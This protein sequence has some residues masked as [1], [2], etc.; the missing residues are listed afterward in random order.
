MKKNNSAV[1]MLS[2]IV[3]LLP[4]ILSIM[5]YNDLPDQ[6]AIHWDISGN[7]DNH[8][9]KAIAA[10]GMPFLFA[11]LNIVSKMRLYN[12]PKRADASLT[13]RTIVAWI[14]PI[15]SVITV[16][17]TLFIS[18]GANIPI[19]VVISALLGAVLV[20]VGNYLPKSRQN[21]TVGIRLPWTLHN[22]DNW[23]KT[24]RL[25]GYLW[26]LGGN[27]LIAGAFV[28]NE[29]PVAGVLL[30][31]ITVVLLIII[32]VCYSFYLHRKTSCTEQENEE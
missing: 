16:P 10:F 9:P 20:L 5:V 21:Y 3:C 22:A 4:L 30:T 25:A 31:V 1:M 18:M 2:S 12:D 23:N 7:P 6:V 29:N 17:I 19:A 28:T 27:A 32:P 8:L 14:I 13:I 11:V 15:T 26:I 24:H